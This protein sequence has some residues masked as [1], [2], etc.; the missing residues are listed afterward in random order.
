MDI[1]LMKIIEF[2]PFY[3]EQDIFSV[4]KSES[5]KWVDRL[6]I[7]ESTKNFKYKDKSLCFS[8]SECEN[9]EYLVIDGKSDFI[10][11]YWGVT[12]KWPFFRIKSGAWR[13]EKY[14]RDY[15]A[16]NIEI[17]DSDILIFSDVD[18]IIDSQYAD[19]IVEM[20][21]KYGIV[22][23]KL[24]FMMFYANLESYNWHEVWPGSPQ[25]YAYRVFF[26][27]GK[28]YKKYKGQINNIRRLGESGKL[29]SDVMCFPI[30]AGF[31]YS[32]MGGVKSV[33]DKMG[34]YAHTYDD[35]GKELLAAKNEGR[36][37]AYIEDFLK[38]GK[39]FFPNHIL[40]LHSSGTFCVLEGMRA[41]IQK[42][43]YLVLSNEN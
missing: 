27:T 7:T 19:E 5:L 32:W 9:I 11:C 35:H 29:Y 6:V 8:D 41:L 39:S 13:N 18:E 31:H 43:K 1:L 22:T 3:N 23:V 33:I 40:K 30:F 15:P 4:K 21:K 10:D 38:H 42:K 24:K 26:M 12:K 28:K 36:L 34:A 17:D 16:N 20:T 25:H 14:Q 2:S 37:E